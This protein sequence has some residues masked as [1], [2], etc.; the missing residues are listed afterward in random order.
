[1]REAKGPL[2][3]AAQ[4]GLRAAPGRGRGAD[5]AR[6]TPTRRRRR[7][8]RSCSTPTAS[9]SPAPGA[10]PASARRSPG[11]S[12]CTAGSPCRAG[13]RATRRVDWAQSSALMVR[14]EAAAAGRLPRPRLLRLLRRVRLRQAPRR[15]RLAHALRPRRRGGPP[16]PALHRPRRRPAADRRIPPQPRPL[17]AQA[18]LA[19]G[20]ARGPRPHRLVLRRLRALAATVSPASRPPIYWAHARQALFPER[21]ESTPR[22]RPKTSGSDVADKFGSRTYRPIDRRGG[23]PRPSARPRRPRGRGRRRRW[24]AAQRGYRGGD[25]AGVAQAG[26]PARSSAVKKPLAK[27]ASG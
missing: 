1:M 23:R 7:R 27:R 24:A 26:Q 12:S 21:G 4:R 18:P 17:H 6:S 2:L 9:R 19:G 10:S 5:R 25:L 15:R 20:G 8:G 3:P 13:A 22:P 11:R 14:R 16:R